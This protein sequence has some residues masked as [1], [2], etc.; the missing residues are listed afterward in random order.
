MKLIDLAKMMEAT[1]EDLVKYFRERRGID[2]PLEDN[3][4]LSY[5][6]AK[7]ANWRLTPEIFQSFITK[8]NLPIEDEEE[9][10][11]DQQ[12]SKEEKNLQ[13]KYVIIG[14]IKNLLNKEESINSTFK[15]FR[16][17]QREWHKIG[18]VP[19]SKIKDLWDTYHFNVENFYDYIKINKKLRDLDLKKNLE[20]KIGLC[21]KAEELLLEP[22]V[23]RA[24][25]T[26]K[27]Y[28][29]QWNEIGPV[30]KEKKDDI[31]QRFKAATL[32]INKIHQQ[33]LEKSKNDIRNISEAQ[34]SSDEKI[35][36]DTKELNEYFTWSE[37]KLIEEILIHN[38]KDKLV[39]HGKYIPDYRGR[40]F[41][42]IVGITHIDGSILTYPL[43]LGYID[44]VFVFS[45]EL[46]QGQEYTFQAQIA[47]RRNR[48][49]KQ[50]PFLI[51]VNRNNIQEVIELS[52]LSCFLKEK[53]SELEQLE[54]SL[55]NTASDLQIENEKIIN[56]IEQI[57]KEKQQEANR[58]IEEYNESIQAKYREIE[59]AEQ[60]ISRLKLE[61]SLTDEIIKEL[62]KTKTDMESS[63]KFLGQKLELCKNLEF[64]T[65][66]DADKYLNILKSETIK[67]PENHL[68]F[69]KDFDGDFA[70]VTEHVH[71]F[72][73]KE[74]GLIYTKFQIQN[75]LSLLMTHDIIVL[76]GLSG[77]G[78]TQIIKSFAE[79]LG[80]VAKII[81]VKPN[82]TSSDDLLGYYNPIQSSFLPTPFTEAIAE[83]IQN[84][85]QLYFICLDE[86]NLARAE[87]YFA[88]F[89]SKLEE[90]EQVPEI[91]L[92]AK[93][94]EDLFLSEFSTLLSLFENALK[95]KNITSWQDFLSNDD[96]RNRFFELLGSM[97]KE[98]ML[99]IH[100]K[101]KRRL[102]DILKFP[103]TIKIP[104]NIRFIGAI[105]V[106]E[107]TNYFSPK[108]LDR[109]HIVKFENP[110]LFESAVASKL[111]DYEYDKELKPIYL[112]PSYLGERQSLPKLNEDGSESLV[113]FLKEINK[114]Y[115]L[116]LSIDFGVRSMRQ[117]INYANCLKKTCAES[118]ENTNDLILNTII[119]QKILP[120]FVFDGNE[121][122]KNGET[123]M[124]LLKRFSDKLKAKLESIDNNEYDIYNTGYLSY[125]YI[126]DLASYAEVNNGQINFY[127]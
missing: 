118:D 32:K 93:H 81:P 50:N 95:G 91:E 117:A 78:K 26:L 42:F 98:T 68:D 83:A 17:I 60:T 109:V 12:N 2:I 70:K 71:L 41:G 7:K 55:A 73:Y 28:Q 126:D 120:R 30:P 54:E 47:K 34:V 66:G 122:L 67:N 13:K 10:N 75:F 106:D 58:I 103:S 6:V 115:L 27:K 69:N 9:I 63:I 48:E 33:Y 21:E 74:K 97:E 127:V 45:D 92:F 62:L 37:K 123:K 39:L 90:R 82:W 79:A 124:E 18:P 116:N 24:F 56:Q 88:D 112:H 114:K 19:Q 16:E 72:L 65:D 77:S 20:V 52:E 101:M 121:T 35:D 76:S 3:F 113:N 125:K 59:S 15:E 80:G 84:P 99:K 87:Y 111:D 36:I 100:S 23:I 61:Q 44:S 105:N 49:E 11:K 5:E 22:S 104:S 38:Q 53:Q 40:S 4:E 14:K 107:T 43:N 108:I 64:I 89:L 85:N 29:E 31:W 94:E 1:P 57:K 96:A 25:N 8:E 110:L 46:K 86:M 119:N 51:Q 102:I